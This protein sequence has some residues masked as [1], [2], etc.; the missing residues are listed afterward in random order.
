MACTLSGSGGGGGS[1]GGPADGAGRRRIGHRLLLLL[2]PLVVV[3]AGVENEVFFHRLGLGRASGGACTLSGSGRGATGAAGAAGRRVSID[4]TEAVARSAVATGLVAAAGVP[5]AQD[6]DFR[7]ILVD[8]LS[9]VV[10]VT[11]GLV[12]RVQF[13]GQV[14]IVELIISDDSS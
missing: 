4:H 2:L 9:P 7:G 8:N 14:H 13:V 6:G 3:G 5:G 12:Q 1:G 11:G 10:V